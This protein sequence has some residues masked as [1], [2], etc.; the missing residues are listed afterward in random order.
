MKKFLE[1]ILVSGLS[2]AA[3]GAAT[4]VMQNEGSIN[5]KQIGSVAAAGAVIGLLSWIKKSPRE[6]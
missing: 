6:K 2:A 3:I 5:L 4:A 1:G